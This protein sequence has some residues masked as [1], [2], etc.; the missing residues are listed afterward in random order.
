MG[1]GLTYRRLRAPRNDGEALIEPSPA[2]VPR[3]LEANLALAHNRR[4]EIL[5]HNAAPLVRQARQELGDAALRYTREYRDV[6]AAS[7]N[8]PRPLL[9]SGHQPE[10]FHPGVWCKNFVL[11]GFA[12][13]CGATAINLVIDNDVPHTASIRVPTGT[14][15]LPR[16]ESVPLDRGLAEVPYEQRA[17]IDGDCFASFGRRVEQTLAPL[18][19]HPLVESWWPT[20]VEASRRTGNLG[21]SLAEARHRLEG[22]WGLST[23]ELPLSAACGLDAWRQF[24]GHLL[25]NLPRLQ[26]DYN[27]SLVDYRRVAGIRSRTH[28]VPQLAA[29]EGWREAPLWIWS[30]DRPQR[31]RLFV[32]TLERDLELT[33]RDGFR[34][35]IAA[36]ETRLVEQLSALAEEG[37]RIRPRAL[38]TTMYAR[39]LLG[40][41]F[42][43]GIGGS[44]YDELTDEIIRR[45]FGIEPPGYCTVTATRQLLPMRPAER[46]SELREI[47]RT[48]RDLRFNPD[49]HLDGAAAEDDTV[50]RWVD[51]KRRSIAED[52][53]AGRR[54]KRHRRIVESNEHLAPYVENVHRELLQR[55]P[56]VREA[57]RAARVLGSR[58]F[59]FC[60]FPEERLR[61]WLLE[62]SAA[63]S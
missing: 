14:L 37:V 20:A 32:R 61:N 50:L 18:V 33:D 15:E 16:L 63:T 4:L 38:V 31:R 24:T 41:L 56:R 2:D 3:L 45:F 7:A 39:L 55:R 19:R 60:L 44:K 34:R 29:E 46:E 17:V 6:D 28:P 27:S 25:L 43:H 21:R 9:L 26:A 51:Q 22:R 62:L 1:G 12:Q 30:D 42:L 59:A 57:L 35:R 49:R 5:G 47:D 13:R 54:L 58:E 52:P 36:S 23:L 8:E 53:P 10:L 11:A 48:L 40:D